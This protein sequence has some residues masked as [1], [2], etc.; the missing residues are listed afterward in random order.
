M[1][2]IIFIQQITRNDISPAVYNILIGLFIILLMSTFIVKKDTLVFSCALGCI[3]AFCIGLALIFAPKDTYYQ[4]LL[5]NDIDIKEFS[6]KYEIV[7]QQGISY[8]IQEK[9]NGNN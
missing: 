1:D 4:V 5:E 8:I 3:L 6:L 7:E 9:E 2:G